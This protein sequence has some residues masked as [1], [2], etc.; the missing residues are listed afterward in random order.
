M[1]QETKE[2][3][4]ILDSLEQKSYKAEP[5][6]FHETTSPYFTC[7]FAERGSDLIFQFYK[8]GKSTNEIIL[9]RVKIIF[10]DLLGRL[11]SVLKVEEVKDEMIEGGESVFVLV[12]GLRHNDYARSLLFKEPFVKLHESFSSPKQV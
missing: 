1:T 10:K 11:D 6:I 7:L 4:S 3:N 2:L 12:K 8:T 5:I 9:D